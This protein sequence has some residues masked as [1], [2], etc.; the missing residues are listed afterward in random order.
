MCGFFAIALPASCKGTGA[1]VLEEASRKLRHRGPDD[2]GYLMYSA[3][4]GK[5]QSARGSE[6]AKD[7]ALPMFCESFADSGNFGLVFRRLAILDLSAAGHQPMRSE[8]GRFWIAFNGEVYNFLELR[9]ELA[10]VGHNFRTQS[11]TEVLLAAFRAWGSDCFRRLEGMFALLILDVQERLLFVARDH[12]GIKPLFYAAYRDGLVFASEAKVLM[13][14]PGFKKSVDP[15][16]VHQYLR[17]GERSAADTTLVKEIAQVP[18]AHWGTVR[19]DRPE[20]ISLHRYWEIPG[21][22]DDVTESSASAEVAELFNRS[23]RLHLRS[24]VPVGVCLSG[25]LDSTAIAMAMR[26]ELPADREVHAF[27]YISD[28]RHLSEERFVDL[29]PGVVSHKVTPDRGEF[30]RDID[31]L[32][33][34]QDFPFISLS[35]YAQYQV[36]RLARKCGINVVLDGQ[37]A[38]EIFCGYPS[39]LAPRVAALLRQGK[40]AAAWQVYAG[41]D[42]TKMGLNLWMLKAIL[43][44]ILPDSRQWPDGLSTRFFYPGWLNRDWFIANDTNPVLR[45][46]TM[47]PDALYNDLRMGI[48]DLSLPQLLRYEDRNSMRFSIESR[49]PFCNHRLVEYAARLPAGLLVSDRG[50]TKHILKQALS[51]LVPNQIRT[52]AKVGFAATDASWLAEA[53]DWVEARLQYGRS[54]QVNCLVLPVAADLI[55]SSIRNN[56]AWDPAAWRMLNLLAWS[57][58]NSINWG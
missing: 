40:L 41:S 45:S 8:D 12:F 47:S 27:S 5:V 6:S 30:A 10:R 33:F 16:A 24:D 13:S 43:A 37:G 23:I 3:T 39:H 58:Q 14:L 4:S 15:A 32:I 20:S 9:Q 21:G 42:T 38:D 56:R 51:D 44:R 29:V 50:E 34:A 11:D 26:R 55:R 28:D 18:A 2:E 46:L 31:D 49:V 54:A 22:I 1:Y 35:V 36:F 52:R 48:S 7:V 25:G 53:P 19:L 17:F 57:E